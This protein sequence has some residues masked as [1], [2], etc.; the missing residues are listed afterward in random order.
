MRELYHAEGLDVS[1]VEGDYLSYRPQ[2]PFDHAVM[3][4]VIEHL[5][6]Y[7]K[8]CAQTW[9]LLKPGA[10]LYLDGS[11]SIEKFAMTGFTRKYIWP[12][13]HTFMSLPGIQQTLL[14]H[15]FD[16]LAVE[17]ETQDYELTMRHWASR[18]DT[19]SDHIIPRWGE[20]TYRKFRI[21]LWAGVHAL[22]TNRLQAYH[23]VAA[24]R[25]DPGPRPSIPMRA[26]A[27]IT[28]AVG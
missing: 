24:R 25:E 16:V 26:A 19:A 13:H 23:L 4:G 3:Y 12:G 11:A 10:R 7:A 2:E 9:E 5:P 28:A 17:N 1:I 18:F 8:F 27:A 14:R 20:G 6:N 15:G 21:Y 22:A